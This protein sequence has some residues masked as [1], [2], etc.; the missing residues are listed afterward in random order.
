MNERAKDILESVGRWTAE[1]AR[2]WGESIKDSPEAH[3]YTLV[4][5]GLIAVVVRW[6]L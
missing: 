3:C 4:L 1:A 5:G 6:F 2:E